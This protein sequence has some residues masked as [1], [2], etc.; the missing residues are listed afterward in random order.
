M[1]Q[2]YNIEIERAILSAILFNPPL[3]EEISTNLKASD[4]Y[5]P[6]HKKIFKSMGRVFSEHS[7]ISE[8]FLRDDL[9][10]EFDEE[11]IV[12]ILATS[13]VSNTPAYIKTLKE[14]A[15]KRELSSLALEIQKD[16][17]EEGE[18]SS[19]IL[20]TLQS[21]IYSISQD[22]TQSE[23]RDSK[24]VVKETM[25][26][27]E[28]M[29]A[30]GNSLLAGL[31]TGFTSLNRKTAGFKEGD[32]IIIAA[33]PSMGKTSL[34]LNLALKTLERNHGV[35]FFSLEMPAEQ[36]MLRLL[37]SKTS[38]PLQNLNV[39]NLNDEEWQMLGLACS[40]LS[41]KALFIDD[42]GSVN[43]NQLKSKMRSLKSKHPEVE[44][45][46]ID[47][48]QLMNSVGNRDRHLE[49]SEISRGLKMLARELNIP[50]IALSQLNRSLESRADKRPMLS[51]LRESG[52]IE[53]DADLIMFVYRDDVY[54]HREE[55]EKEKEAQ[56]KGQSYKSNFQFKEEEDAELIIGKQRN[57]PTGT[58]KLKFQKSFTRFVDPEDTQIIY[59]E[60]FNHQQ[61]EAN[62]EIPSLTPTLPPMNI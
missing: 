2:S 46:I 37:S 58:V 55:R 56:K 44:V 20:E 59:E 61:S 33:R 31:D 25:L 17:I 13:P 11:A 8:S 41:D 6:A 53:Q 36:L 49:V 18:D 50:I 9:K 22:S 30:R 39:G 45:V 48:L 24:D 52:A 12:E 27:I 57:G 35:A 54:K 26:H 38:I 5:L 7:E 62:I 21:R 29:K 4:F 32:L 47:Y 1:I 19:E 42:N 28:K 60:S 23:F 14:K 40:D 10:S 43:I 15:I 34:V 16:I 51:D 3:Y